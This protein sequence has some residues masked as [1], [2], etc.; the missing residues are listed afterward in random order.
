MINDQRELDGSKSVEHPT[1]IV[2][3]SSSYLGNLNFNKNDSNDED[4]EEI[5]STRKRGANKIY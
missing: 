1:E 2:T 3:K 4:A 5:P